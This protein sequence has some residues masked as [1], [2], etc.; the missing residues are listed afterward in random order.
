MHL[1]AVG[2]QRH[3]GRI[4][5]LIMAKTLL[6]GVSLRSKAT[7]L[8]CLLG[9]SLA[10]SPLA[11][12]N[13][14]VSFSAT[15]L[16]ACREVTTAE[17]AAANPLEK[18]IEAVF[19]MSLLVDGNQDQVDE[20]LVVFSSPLRRLRVA[21]FSPKSESSTDVVG[22]I[23]RSETNDSTR[24]L[25]FGLGGTFGA[26]HEIASA[27]ISP[28]ASNTQTKHSGVKDTYKILPERKQLVASGTIRGDQGV[29]FKLKPSTQEPLEGSREFRATFVVP[30][31][32]R[33]DWISVHCLARGETTRQLVKRIEEIGNAR[34]VVAL[35]LEGDLEA[36]RLARAVEKVQVKAADFQT[37]DSLALSGESQAAFASN[38]RPSFSGLLSFYRQALRLAPS[39]DDLPADTSSKPLT[40]QEAC[41]ALGRLSGDESTLPPQLAQ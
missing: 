1:E 40:L 33:G 4:G 32:W 5:A 9:S 30:R 38:D 31:S 36:K 21:D 17:Y 25:Q 14:A 41:E 27:Q 2:M 28:S 6:F 24:S 26:K 15:H 16:V 37:A 22:P 19:R 10:A 23:E 20:V 39:A 7:L 34:F 8:A 3:R 29:F 12:A 18:Q 11:A 13:P 35:Y